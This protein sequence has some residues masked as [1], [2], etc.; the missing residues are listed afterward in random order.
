MLVVLVRKEAVDSLF[1]HSMSSRETQSVRNG[2]NDT[3]A[4]CINAHIGNCRLLGGIYI[5]RHDAFVT[6]IKTPQSAALC[7]Q[8]TTR[9]AE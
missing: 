2:K 1:I 6:S 9:A 3:N 5:P 4:I 8:K 7:I